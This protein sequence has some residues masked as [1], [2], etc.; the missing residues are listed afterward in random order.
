VDDSDRPV[1]PLRHC[2]FREVAERHG[3]VVCSLHLGLMRGVLAES[4]APLVAERLDPFVDTS[5]CLAHLSPT[6]A[7]RRPN[8]PR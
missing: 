1:I 5:L 3:E 8:G 7:K 4:R 6:S 2:A